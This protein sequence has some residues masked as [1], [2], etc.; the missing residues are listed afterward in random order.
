MRKK[1]ITTFGEQSF[2][3]EE[4]AGLFSKKELQKKKNQKEYRIGKKIIRK[5]IKYMSNGKVRSFIQQL[6]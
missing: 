4:I 1:T 5:V 3:D 2:K 6:Y